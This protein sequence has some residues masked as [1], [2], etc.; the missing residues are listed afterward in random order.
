MADDFLGDHPGLR[1]FVLSD[2][3]LTGTRIGGG[4]YGRVD[5]VAFPVAAAAKTVYAFLQE[6]D[7]TVEDLPKA[8]SEFVRECQLMST[9]R[10]PNIVQF[11]GVTFFPGSRLPALVMEQLLTSL[12]DLLAPDASPTQD[13]VTPL[14]FFSMAL[15][16]SVLQDVANGLAYLH[17]RSPPIIHRDLSARNVLLNSGMVAKIADL[18]VACIAPHTRSSLTMTKGP[19]ALIYM[20]PEAFAPAKSNKEKSK[21]NA[22]I[23]IFSLGVVTIFT[24]GETFPCDPLE[25]NYV[26]EKSGLLVAR[27][28][29]QRRSEYMGCVNIK[30]RACGQLRADQP[31]IRLIQQCLQN[32]PA[33]RPAIHEVQRLLKEARS[34][35]VD[36]ESERNKRYLVRALQTHSPRNQVRALH[37]FIRNVTRDLNRIW[38]VF[39]EMWSVIMQLYN[40][41]IRICAPEYKNYSPECTGS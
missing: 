7:G 31:F 32:L 5:E 3:Q 15:K 26:D 8:A 11:L 33:K 34:C 23:D 12:H 28:E 24:V 35:F 10:H 9:L 13:A 21:Y 4:A 6:S 38:N 29:L 37:S 40:P 14:A 20:P 25:P 19:G 1:P 17:E 18:G 16:C 39:S 36:R 41:E 2:V 22:S 30:L 27:T